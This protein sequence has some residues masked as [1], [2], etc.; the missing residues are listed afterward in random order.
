VSAVRV[1]VVV[2]DEPPKVEGL[3]SGP[4]FAA[5]I[6]NRRTVLFDTGPSPDLLEHNLRE[7]GYEPDDVDF[8]VISHN[9]WDHAG[10]L[11]AVA[12]HVLRVI[13]PERLNAPNEMVREEWLGI[14]DE[15]VL[16]D[17][18]EGPPRERAA[19]VNGLLVTGC[20]HPGV[21]RFAEWCVRRGL[22]VRAVLGGFHLMGA[23][24]REVERIAD[25]LR[26][27][28]VRV[29][30]PCHCS[31]DL[32]KEVFRERFEFVDVGPGL[33]VRI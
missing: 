33:E 28:G 25:R 22:K 16:T 29:A 30:G 15:V 19:F 10:G 11:E 18:L 13:T 9:H 2:S 4:G 7:L 24:R 14:D 32:A 6:E 31:G 5:L 1:T 23:S 21:D 20:A 27:L 26:E 8:V 12:P 17:V 3:K